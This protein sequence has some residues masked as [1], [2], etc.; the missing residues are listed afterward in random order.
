MAIDVT[1]WLRELNYNDTILYRR[2]VPPSDGRHAY[3]QVASQG[4]YQGKVV[5]FLDWGV[6]VR[7]DGWLGDEPLYY[8]SLADILAV[9]RG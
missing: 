9:V 7:A 1:Q 5:D 8:V 6:G 4:P 3:Y 2:A